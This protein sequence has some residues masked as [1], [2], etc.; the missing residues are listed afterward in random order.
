MNNLRLNSFLITSAITIVLYKAGFFTIF[1]LNQF[2]NASKSGTQFANQYHKNLCGKIIKLPVFPYHNPNKNHQVFFVESSPGR[3]MTGR[4]MCAFESALRVGKLPVKVLIRSTQTLKIDHP[5]LCDLVQEFYPDKLSFYN[6]EIPE[7]FAGTPLDGIVER[8][9]WKN[10][11]F[12]VHLSDLMRAAVLF[13]YGGFYLDHD[14][15]TLKDLR[16]I[17]NTIVLDNITTYPTETCEPRSKEKSRMLNQGTMHFQK[18]NPVLLKYLH[19]MNDTYRQGLKFLA[20]GP[21]LVHEAASIVLGYKNQPSTPKK[22]PHLTIAPSFKFRLLATMVK[23]GA[24]PPKLFDLTVDGSY[25]DNFVNCSY[26]LH[27]NGKKSKTRAITGNPHRDAYSYLGP[28]ICPKSF[29]HIRK[30]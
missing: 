26:T 16:Q 1:Y 21:P 12:K 30:F 20:L 14:V 7:L 22:T 8:L 24:R 13:K 19:L 11:H 9:D 25:F 2:P 29:S 5:A 6:V 4:V 23:V 17:Q 10:S 28:K 18:H 27:M 15:I 3:K